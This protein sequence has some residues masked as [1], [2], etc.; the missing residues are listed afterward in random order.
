MPKGSKQVNE[1]TELSE[2]WLTERHTVIIGVAMTSQFSPI[3]AKWKHEPS[4]VIASNFQR[5]WKLILL[6]EIAQF[7]GNLSLLK[8]R[9]ITPFLKK[10]LSKAN[11]AHLLAWPKTGCHL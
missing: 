10:T 6:D 5:S 3:I 4:V 11:K 7:G 8:C 1:T 9:Q 2:N